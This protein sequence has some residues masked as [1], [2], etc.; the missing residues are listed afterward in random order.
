MY[1]FIKDKREPTRNFWE[2]QCNEE[3]YVIN[4]MPIFSFSARKGLTWLNIMS[5]PLLMSDMS[6]FSLPWKILL[7]PV[8]L[9]P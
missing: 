7:H 1:V 2:I 3:Q 6:I 4:L 8:Q 9:Q 5:K